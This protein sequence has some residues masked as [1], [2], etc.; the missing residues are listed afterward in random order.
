MTEGKATT[1]TITAH[2]APPLKLPVLASDGSNWTSWS[3]QV[4]LAAIYFELEEFLEP[5]DK[6]IPSNGNARKLQLM[7]NGNIAPD[8]QSLADLKSFNKTYLNL[9]ARFARN[10]EIFQTR[11]LNKLKLLKASQSATITDYL[12]THENHVQEVPHFD[13]RPGSSRLDSVPPHD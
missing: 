2:D 4:L 3:Y 13:G 10:S 12:A 11:A 5:T 7:I 1:A 6:E 8:L 9:K